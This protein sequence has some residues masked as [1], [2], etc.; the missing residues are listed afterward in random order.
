MFHG[1]SAYQ[2]KKKK[3]IYSPEKHKQ[4]IYRI[5]MFYLLFLFRQ[6]INKYKYLEKLTTV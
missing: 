1:S 3:Q 2:K 4:S 6:K 5:A